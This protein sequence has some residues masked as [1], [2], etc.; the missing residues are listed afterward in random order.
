ME[1]MEGLDDA[2]SSS[3][4]KDT[5]MPPS[6]LPVIHGPAAAQKTAYKQP[7]NLPERC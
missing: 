5:A 7:S 6:S 2:A 4:V 1:G 3:R